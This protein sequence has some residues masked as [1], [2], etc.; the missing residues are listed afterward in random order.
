MTFVQN[1]DTLPQMGTL[2]DVTED[3]IVNEK[4][5]VRAGET[6]TVVATME[7]RGL[8]EIQFR[9]L[10]LLTPWPTKGLARL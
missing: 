2:I 4:R 10:V 3:Q 1:L 8:V 9:R 6:G 5:V 7:Q